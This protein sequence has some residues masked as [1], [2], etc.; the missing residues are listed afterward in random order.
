MPVVSRIATVALTL[1]IALAGCSKQGEPPA[2]VDGVVAS[3]DCSQI[4]AA[5]QANQY[6]VDVGDDVL[7]ARYSNWKRLDQAATTR[8]CPPANGVLAFLCLDTKKGY[9]LADNRGAKEFCAL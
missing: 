7:A 6:S 8:K 2:S 4:S 1:T 9:G 3:G 5:I